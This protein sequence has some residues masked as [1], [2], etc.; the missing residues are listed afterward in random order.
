MVQGILAKPRAASAP[1]LIISL[2]QPDEESRRGRRSHRSLSAAPALGPL[3]EARP[4][5]DWAPG[6]CRRVSIKPARR[7]KGRIGARQ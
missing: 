2:S 5:A 1:V 6:S 3:W 4:R 7:D